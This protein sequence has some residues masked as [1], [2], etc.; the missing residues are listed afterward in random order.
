MVSH[1]P[2]MFNTSCVCISFLL[3]D[4][5]GLAAESLRFAAPHPS[6]DNR[7]TTAQ[8]T[9][10]TPVCTRISRVARARALVRVRAREKEKLVRRGAMFFWIIFLFH[11]S[12]QQG[13][14]HH[15]KNLLHRAG[16]V[17]RKK[18]GK[19]GRTYYNSYRA[20]RKEKKIAEP[21]GARPMTRQRKMD[22]LRVRI[23]VTEMIEQQYL[24]KKKAKE[25]VLTLLK[26]EK[27]VVL[28][29]RERG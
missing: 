24:T 5:E 15:C 2:C 10:T 22:S 14:V 1:S 9:T 16:L 12:Q 27:I 3:W 17:E 21:C 23:T 4:C 18:E 6:N 11:Q 13:K 29:K 7:R 26:K 28:G 8:A 25:E 19:N 20:K